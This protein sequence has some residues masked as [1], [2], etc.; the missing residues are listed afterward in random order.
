MVEGNAEDP[1]LLRPS[2]PELAMT[3]QRANRLGFAIHAA[4]LLCTDAADLGARQPVY[5]RFDLDMN[6]CLDLP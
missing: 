6:T 1:W 4:R 5:G 3:K 2:E